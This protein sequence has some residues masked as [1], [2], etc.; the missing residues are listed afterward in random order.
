MSKTD[1]VST[2]FYVICSLQ[3]PKTMVSKFLATIHTVYMGP[4]GKCS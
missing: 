1:A 2:M 3:Q 4:E